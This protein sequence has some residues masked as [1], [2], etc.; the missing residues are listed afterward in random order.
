[1][2]ALVRTGPGGPQV[3]Q[4]KSDYPTP[5]PKEDHILIR[6]KC[7]GLNR[8][9][10]RSRAGD[11]PARGEFPSDELFTET[12]PAILGEECVGTVAD[13]GGRQDFELG[14]TVATYFCGIGK[15]FD[16]SYAEYTLAPADH[17]YKI[18][19]KLPFEILGAIPA[20]FMTAWGSLYRA[21]HIHNGDTLLIHGGTSSVGTAAIILAK[22]AGCYVAAT[23]RKADKVENLKQSGADFVLIDGGTHSLSEQLKEHK[24]FKHGARNVLEL[25]G[26][27]KL[28]EAFTCTAPYGT[29]CVTGVLTK[30]WALKEWAPADSIESGKKIT[31]YQCPRDRDHEGLEE[32]LNKIVRAVESKD[33]NIDDF[34]GRKL[35]SL[36]GIAEGHRMMQANE[37][38]GKV[39]VKL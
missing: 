22:R 11:P 2:R 20:T 37:V 23:T 24:A 10:L 38:Q 32:V 15:I 21:L 26:P 13:N 12:P 27:D 19:T 5:S 34:I 14:D 25:I 17:V 7:C 30:V 4:V 3:L 16:G 8:A 6:V 1:M 29:I 36:E 18:D 35:E 28:A 9:E 33:I 31:T 39:V